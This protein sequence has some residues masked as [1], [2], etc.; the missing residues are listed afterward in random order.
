MAVSFAR[1]A[2]AAAPVSPPYPPRSVYAKASGASDTD[3]ILS[4]NASWIVPDYPT[5]RGGGN[6]PGFWYGIEPIP[7]DVLIQPILAYGDGV[8]DFQIFTGFYDWHDGN[9]VQS[10]VQNVKP[11]TVVSGSIIW[12]AATSTYTQSIWA[13]NGAPISTV[14][15]R[16]D[17]HNE[18][19]T[20]LYFVIEHQPND[21][22]EYPANGGITFTDI[23]A[24]WASGKA[25]TAADWA[26]AQ[27]KPSCN[28]NGIVKNATT[29]EFTWDT[30]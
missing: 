16:P 17:E 24:E 23:A 29:L 19:F 25:L 22:R 18:V 13:G 6:A 9:W 15:S 2:A 5:T 7:A 3:R 4:A 8:P 14:V 1:R 27:F 30:K 11:G 28:S 20:S 26:V 10:R 12:N 21:C